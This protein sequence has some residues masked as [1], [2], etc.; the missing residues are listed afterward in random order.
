MASNTKLLQPVNGY[1]IFETN[2]VLTANHLNSIGNYFDYHQRLTRARLLG[3]GIVCGLNPGFTR[4]TILVSKGVGVTSDGDVLMVDADMQFTGLIPFDNKNVGYP[5]FLK[6]SGDSD[7]TKMWEL[8]TNAQSSAVGFVKVA[9]FFGDRKPADFVLLLYIDQYVKDTDNCSG[10]DCDGKADMFTNE[11]KVIVID[12][13]DYSKIVLQ[14]TCNCDSYFSMPEVAIPRVFLNENDNLFSYSDLITAYSTAITSGAEAL[15]APLKSAAETASLLQECDLING[16]S[17]RILTDEQLRS[18][19]ALGNFVKKALAEKAQGIQYV[20]DYL[21]DICVAY[22]EFKESAFELCYG[23]CVDA[24][25]F[26]KHLA[27]GLLQ[28][29][30][31]FANHKYRNS[32]IESP[33]LNN[34]DRKATDALRL[35]A[36]LADIITGFD[37]PQVQTIRITPSE[38]IDRSLDRRSIPYYYKPDTLWQNWSAEK[39]RRGRAATNLSYFAGTYSAL[40]HV[41]EP[42]KYDIDQYPFFRIE[43]HIGRIFSSAY[44]TIDNLR[45]QFDLPFDIVGVQLQKERI[46]F[47]VRPIRPGVLDVLFEKEKLLFDNKLDNLVKYNEQLVKSLP[48]DGE[49]SQ[50]AIT[51]DYGD[52][53][54]LRATMLNKKTELD[55]HING[56]KAELAKPAKETAGKVAWNDLHVTMASTGAQINKNAKL[57]TA[58][59]YRSPLENLAVIEQPKTLQWLGDLLIW[60]G[61]K[62][63][64]GYIFK[65]FLRENPSMLHNAGVCK[66]GTFVLVYDTTNNI[67]TVVADFYLPYIAKDEL[68]DSKVE[69]TKV[70]KIPV[71]NI[72]YTI[73]KDIIK[74]PILNKDIFSI[75]DDLVRVK[76]LTNKTDLKI[77]QKLNDFDG[78][79]NNVRG[80]VIANGVN[81]AK[82]VDGVKEKYE[83]SFSRLI[84]SYDTVVSKNNIKVRPGDD[85]SKNFDEMIDGVRTEFTN[86]I[87]IV[88]MNF[89]SKINLVKNDLT[90]TNAQIKNTLDGINNVNAKLD[91]SKAELSK[92][93]VDRVAAADAKFTQAQNALDQKINTLSADTDVKLRASEARLNQ[94]IVNNGKEFDSKLLTTKSEAIEAAN[95]NTSTRLNAQALEMNNKFSAIDNTLKRNNIIN[96]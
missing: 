37:I 43:G 69:P 83:N 52:P 36:R 13:S 8:A 17:R 28:D 93:T 74:T 44:S 78:R 91:A 16:S 7:Q 71:F 29:D 47:P 82:A 31:S 84:S 34:K 12:K 35:F 65:N 67:S 33:I 79:I 95:K 45:K 25:T 10:E 30:G 19:S 54:A 87:S 81:I 15:S 58:A 94:Q 40:P 76:D 63:Q 14:K 86:R 92:N 42:L 49:L 21:K 55:A 88:E 23:C 3:V 64:E 2:Q 96:R 4:E 9:D 48:D 85:A 1:S 59:A 53:K 56:L 80:E 5:P 75:K 39:A 70:P 32:F 73:S 27:L 38:D 6:I 61:N 68:V 24:D 26:A 22:N 46:T 41:T 72:D 50:D 11:L 18:A 57:F 77:D 60:Q 62:V 51:K 66:G 89:D 20:H 90:G